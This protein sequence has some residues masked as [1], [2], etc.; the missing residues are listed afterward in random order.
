MWSD[1]IKILERFYKNG[2][3]RE[4]LIGLWVL[5]TVADILY[6][7]YCIK[8][9]KVRMAKK[10]VFDNLDF[11]ET[12]FINLNVEFMSSCI[13]SAIKRSLW[14]CWSFMAGKPRSSRSNSLISNF[15]VT[16]MVVKSKRSNDTKIESVSEKIRHH[17]MSLN[18]KNI[19]SKVVDAFDWNKTKYNFIIKIMCSLLSNSI[20]FLKVWKFLYESQKVSHAKN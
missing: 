5:Y 19:V 12:S 10:L 11:C 8:V 4:R 9:A 7:T 14:N 17:I 16:L 2:P 13:D 15:W 18:W 6:I 20:G 1:L 3:L